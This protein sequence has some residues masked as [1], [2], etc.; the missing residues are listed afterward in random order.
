MALFIVRHQHSP[1]NC[2]ASDPYTGA[3][4]LN[5]LSR[6]N[7]SRYGLEILGEA[8]VPGEHAMYAI[9]KADDESFVR[10]FMKPFQGAGTVDIHR[11]STCAGVV[12]N[13]GCGATLP[14]EDITPTLDPEETCQRAIDDGLVI[15]RAHPLNGETSIPSLLGVIMPNARFYV[16]NHFGIP[17][18]DAAG[19]R[20]SVRGLADRPLD[21]GIDDLRRLPSETRVVTLEC[22]GN[23]R[24]RFDP[25][26]P[27]EQWDLGAVSTAE[28]TGVPLTEVLDRAGAR[29]STQEVVFRGADAGGIDGHVIV[30]FERSLPYALARSG[31][32]LLA[33]AMNGE[34]LPMEH[35]YPLRL[36]VPGWYAVASV[37]WLTE[38]ELVDRAFEGH[39]QTDK[40]CYEWSRAG[41]IVRE[42]VTIQ[43]VRALITEPA[44]DLEVRSGALTVRGVAWSGAAPIARVD[45]SVGDG[46]WQE[47]RLI[48][49]AR[50]RSWQGWELIASVPSS[51]RSCCARARPIRRDARSRSGPS[52]IDSGTAI[53]PFTK[54]RSAFGRRG[55]IE[56]SNDHSCR[57]LACAPR[58][59]RHPRDGRVPRRHVRPSHR[60]VGLRARV[61]ER[62]CRLGRPPGHARHRP[63][64]VRRA[65]RSGPEHLPGRFDSHDRRR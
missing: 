39:Y 52:G 11:A 51:G 65:R 29:Q 18:L 47:A 40:Y 59:A 37:K 23:G 64:F 12:A 13:G 9:V 56:S 22:A 49:D 35:G 36:I 17:R 28:W 14:A 31:E 53:T 41:R 57:S 61:H 42:P 34:P 19:F 43:Q 20:L 62:L 21:L 8:V 2:P 60:G 24:S 15:H 55:S 54:S 1:E 25:A 26:V 27:G 32:V 30:R 50:S 44:P 58:T 4:L 46:H 63:H 7:V 3:M 45:V 38:I 48:G 5:H 6:P 33:Y 16:R 10:E